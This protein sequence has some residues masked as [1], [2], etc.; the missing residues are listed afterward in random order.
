MKLLQVLASLEQLESEA[1]S[2]YD[3]KLQPAGRLGT[4]TEGGGQ[5]NWEP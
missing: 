1:L 2:A 3:Q 5:E 4:S